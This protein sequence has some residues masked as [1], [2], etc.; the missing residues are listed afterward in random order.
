LSHFSERFI[1]QGIPVENGTA[2]FLSPRFDLASHAFMLELAS[3]ST[4]KI[5]ARLKEKA[6]EKAEFQPPVSKLK[7]ARR[8]HL[9]LSLYRR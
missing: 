5:G 7:R 2:F 4:S 3:P 6:K 1:G 8:F 9:S